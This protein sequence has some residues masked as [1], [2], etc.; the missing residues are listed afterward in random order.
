VFNIT[1]NN[2]SD[3]SWQYVL[4]TEEPEIPKK[5]TDLQQVTDKLYPVMSYRIHL[6]M[7]EIRTHNVNGD[8]H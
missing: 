2:V 7:S 8:R 4:L 6:T 3:I 5:T 1:F